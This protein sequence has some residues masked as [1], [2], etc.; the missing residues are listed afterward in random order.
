MDYFKILGLIREPFSNSPE[1]EFFFQSPQHQG[2]L[3]K[4]ELAIRLRRGLNIVLGEVGTGKTTLCRQ[5]IMK[6]SDNGEGQ[7]EIETHLLLDPSFDSALE[8]L[9]TVAL[10]LG[11]A[12]SDRQ[13]SEWQLKEDIKNY[14]FRRGVDENKIVVLII[15]E[16]QKLPDFCL[17]ILREF[18]NYETNEYKLLQIVIFAQREFEPTLNQYVNFTDRI[19]LR[20]LLEPLDFRGTRE[21]ILFR[22]KKASGSERTKPLFTFPALWAIHRETGGF[23]RK[24]ITLCHQVILSLI[25]QNK[26][27]AGYRLVRSCAGRNGRNLSPGGVRWKGPALA[28]SVLVVLAAFIFYFDPLGVF[29]DTTAGKRRA[30]LSPVEIS[31]RGGPESGKTE[32]ASPEFSQPAETDGAMR[33]ADLPSSGKAGMP[34]YLGEITL[35][36]GGAVWIVL[37]RVYGVVDNSLLAAVNAANPGLPDLNRVPKG[38]RIRLPAYA[39][40]ARPLP[41]GKFWVLLGKRRYV[42]EAYAFLRNYSSDWPAARMLPYWNAREGLIFALMVRQGYDNERD[43]A[44]AIS[45]LPGTFSSDAKILS[46]LDDGTVFFAR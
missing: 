24:I 12:E 40:K 7:A 38:H 25:I 22:L 37:E 10:S 23:P 45:A 28:V 17:E 4:V 34:E 8:F 20:Y 11:I 35:V 42:E 27:R 31:P 6:F 16:G 41:P 32:T 30:S 36:E 19:N 15:D 39:T 29:R 1:P 3:Q 5:L 18:L 14:L 2:C 44:A 33:K 26:T 43:A 9:K 13:N 21:M 46:R